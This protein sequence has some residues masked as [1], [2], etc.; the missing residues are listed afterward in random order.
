MQILMCA[1]RRIPASVNS[2]DVKKTPDCIDEKASGA[3]NILLRKV[4]SEADCSC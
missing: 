2:T 1:R 4:C 3:G